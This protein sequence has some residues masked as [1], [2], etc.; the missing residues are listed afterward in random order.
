MKN[1]NVIYKSLYLIK[2][3]QEFYFLFF[4]SIVGV[5]VELLSIAVVVPIVVFLI[6]QD[7]VE[8][9]EILRPVFNLFS[10]KSKEDVIYF[11]LIGILLVYFFRFIF[12]IFLNY[13][14]NL[15][16]YNLSLTIKKI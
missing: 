14:K 15:F 1:K 5:F 12:L 8:K 3:K 2:N 10:I 16:S 7:P 13:R 6:E 9:Y 11:G 4:L